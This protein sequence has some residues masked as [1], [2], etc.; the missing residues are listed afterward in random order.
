MKKY[1]IHLNGKR[2][3]GCHGCE[4]HCKTNKNLPVGPFLCEISY[5]PLKKI[6]GIPRTRFTISVGTNAINVSW[7]G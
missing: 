1:M 6:A 2:C 4:V 5:M 7:S 3:I